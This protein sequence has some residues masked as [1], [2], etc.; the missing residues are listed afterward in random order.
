LV[1]GAAASAV[2]TIPP[3]PIN[4]N[5]TIFIFAFAMSFDVF[6]DPIYYHPIYY[7]FSLARF[8]PI[9]VLIM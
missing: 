1:A 4:T 3:I 9:V 8:T 2:Q 5:P 7:P 6:P